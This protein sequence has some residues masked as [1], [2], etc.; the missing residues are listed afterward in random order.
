MLFALQMHAAK[1]HVCV[2]YAALNAERLFLTWRER[3]ALFT[4]SSQLLP[5]IV[6]D[7][8]RLRCWAVFRRYRDKLPPTFSFSRVFQPRRCWNEWCCFL[9]LLR[10]LLKIFN[11]NFKIF[12]KSGEILVSGRINGRCQKDSVLIPWSYISQSQNDIFGSKMSI[13]VKN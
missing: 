1:S 13:S 7:L 4:I 10:N 9:D 8:K 6:L 3:A 11:Y 2:L 5:E 12:Q